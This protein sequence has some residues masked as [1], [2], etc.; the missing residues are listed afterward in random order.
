MWNGRPVGGGDNP[1]VPAYT[2][3]VPLL[4]GGFAPNALARMAKHGQGYV[5]GSM[6]PGMVADAFDKARAAWRDG[7][8]EGDPRLVAI[9]YYALGEPDTGRAKVG[10]YYSNLGE[11][12]KVVVDN[13][14]T[15][16]EAVRAAVKEFADLGAD[17]LIFN[18]ATDE[19]DDV[20]RLAEIVL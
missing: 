17:E 8:R 16:P 20:E 13:V 5:G 1:A 19:I 4:F 12:A 2:R 15:T 6:P 7:G 3:E 9:V 14:R 11:L 10:D 18:P